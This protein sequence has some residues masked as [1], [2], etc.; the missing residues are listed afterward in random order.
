MSTFTATFCK[1]QRESTYKPAAEGF[2]WFSFIHFPR[3]EGL[4]C[5]KVSVSRRST[6][7]MSGWE[8]WERRELNRTK[9]SSPVSYAGFLRPLHVTKDYEK[10]ESLSSSVQQPTSCASIHTTLYLSVIRLLLCEVGRSLPVLS[11]LCTA[12]C[13][14]SIL[15]YLSKGKTSKLLER[16]LVPKA[17]TSIL[18]AAW[19]NLFISISLSVKWSN[20][21]ASLLYRRQH[22]VLLMK[23]L[24]KMPHTVQICSIIISTM[25]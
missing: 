1:Q 12:L 16:T 14:Y 21:P 9:E 22:K 10:S 18:I 13:K 15:F 2:L 11:T 24:W 20:M 3:L 6:D 8:P 4:G 17:K 5:C 23:M 7:L 19:V 25:Q